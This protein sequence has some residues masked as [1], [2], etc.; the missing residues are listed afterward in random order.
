MPGWSVERVC[1]SSRVVAVRD[2][3]SVLIHL[4]MQR[5]VHSSHLLV[6]APVEQSKLS[7]E[8]TDDVETRRLIKLAYTRSP[9]YLSAG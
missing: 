2:K 1:R 5:Q 6:L 9:A 8:K 4:F 7:L 3:S